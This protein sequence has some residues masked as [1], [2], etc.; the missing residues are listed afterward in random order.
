M[1]LRE[2]K[3]EDKLL[4]LERAGRELFSELGFEAT[5]TRALAQHAGIG[6]GTFFVYFPHKLDL[7]VHLFLVDVG[8][9]LDDA[10]A[11][12]EPDLPLV[13]SLMHV[14]GKLYDYYASDPRLSRAFM[15]EMIF[16]EVRPAAD[17]T[18]TTLRR[19]DAALGELM[20]R[21]TGLVQAAKQRGE[22]PESIVDLEATYHLFGAYYWSLMMRL[23]G[24]MPS[25]EQ[26]RWLLERS[27]RALVVGLREVV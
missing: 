20:M 10:F 11:T 18:T 17:M 1:S 2:Q 21:F 14:C 3:K 15:K 22:L 16:L 27:L 5:T 8:K 13:D 7:L 4:R 9:V 19:H 25:R 24:M 6:A 23:G 26:Q 12:L